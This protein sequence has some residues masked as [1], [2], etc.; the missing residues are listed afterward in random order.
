MPASTSAGQAQVWV[1]QEAK[2]GATMIVFSGDL[3]KALAFFTIAKRGMERMFDIMLPS[4]AGIKMIQAVMKQKNVDSM[5][6]MIALA[7]KMGVK[8]VACTMSM[9]IMGIKEEE[10][11]DGV[12]F[13]GDTMDSNLNLF[14]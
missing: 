6:A 8:M 5:P 4:H 10:I 13:G 1:L 3:D 11:I 12:E 7:Q 9:D 2:D 14:I